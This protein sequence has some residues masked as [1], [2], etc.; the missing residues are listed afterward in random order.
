LEPDANLRRGET[1]THARKRGEH[2]VDQ[3]PVIPRDDLG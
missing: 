2:V 1:H 3:M